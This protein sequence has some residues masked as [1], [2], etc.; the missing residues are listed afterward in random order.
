MKKVSELKKVNEE[1]IYDFWAYGLEEGVNE[2][3]ERVMSEDVYQFNEPIE[4]ARHLKGILSDDIANELEQDAYE[5]LPE[6]V[7]NTIG[8]PFILV[9]DDGNEVIIN[10]D[11]AREIIPD[12]IRD[13]LIKHGFDKIPFSDLADVFADDIIR[14]SFKSPEEINEY[15]AEV[16]SVINR[17][18]T[19]NYSFNPWKRRY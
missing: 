8:N 1:Y 15:I 14:N 3:A 16:N 11:N 18:N 9:Q 10:E 4:D 2:V 5:Q 19:S 6:I 13:Q 7:L 12:V 17:N